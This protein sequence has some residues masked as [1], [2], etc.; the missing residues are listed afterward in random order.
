[1]SKKIESM[2]KTDKR[3]SSAPVITMLL[4]KHIYSNPQQSRKYFDMKKLQELAA[5]IKEE[6]ILS[7]II[8]R[9]DGRRRYLIIAGERRYRACCMLG[10]ERI[11]VIVKMLSEQS[12]SYQMM[13]ENLQRVDISPLEEARAYRKIMDDFRLTIEQVAKKVGV[14]QPYRIADR[15]VLLNLK[16]EYQECLEK[17]F[18]TATQ[19]FYLAKVSAE[20]QP[21]FFRMIRDGKVDNASLASAAQYFTEA[22]SQRRMFDDVHI[23]QEELRLMK[24]IERQVEDI[25]RRLE[26]LINKEGE[27][28]IANRVA[29]TRVAIVAEK[30]EVMA[31][32]MMTGRR[33]LLESATRQE[34]AEVLSIA[35]VQN[36]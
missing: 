16:S 36:S 10:L 13:I 22:A 33:I 35:Q 26:C 14:L 27:I 4:L 8:V 12:A 32:L 6:G 20:F 31:K 11:P 28:D 25:G 5:S 30:L 18:I 17:S 1:M 3:P 24:N 7:P 21:Q 2:S 15:L 19:A 29:P 34:K 23:S 9:P